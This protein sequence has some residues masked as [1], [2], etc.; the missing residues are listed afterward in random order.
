M[1]IYETAGFPNPARV[2]IALA[3]KGMTDK[4]TFEEVDVVGGAHRKPEF[5]AKNPTAT[6]PVLELSDGTCI[7]ECS[8]ITEYIDHVDEDPIL[9]GRTARERAQI[10]MMQRLDHRRHQVGIFFLQRT[11]HLTHEVAA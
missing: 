3:E 11:A 6:V 10:S 2:R 1:K 5:L 8:A 4:V 7:G 9:T